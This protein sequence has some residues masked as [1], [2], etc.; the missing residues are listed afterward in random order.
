M[1]T[2][3]IHVQQEGI[4]EPLIQE[5]LQK[6]VDTIVKLLSLEDCENTRIGDQASR[7]ISGGEKRRLSIGEV[8]VTRAR[9]LLLDEV[10]VGCVS[11]R[12]DLPPMR[13]FSS[14]L[15]VAW[16]PVWRTK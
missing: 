13:P 2:L 6:R 14:R 9:V 3:L 5:I 11:L 7:G 8:L 4:E 16:I 10:R 1:S 15:L 12:L